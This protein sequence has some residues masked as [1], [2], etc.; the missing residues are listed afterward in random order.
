M[1]RY[2]PH[3]QQDRAFLI[4]DD[5][6]PVGEYAVIDLEEDLKIAEKKVNNIV[7]LLNGSTDLV[8]LGH[9]TQSQMF[10]HKKPKETPEAKTEIVF[11]VRKTGTSKPNAVLNIEG[12]I[13]E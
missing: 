12:G 13:L 5:S 11:Y 9:E 1:F 6:K 2:E 7:L 8:Q 10:F 4:L 3:P